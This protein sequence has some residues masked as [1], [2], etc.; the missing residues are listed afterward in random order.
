[1]QTT[2][3]RAHLKLKRARPFVSA[4]TALLADAALLTMAAAAFLSVT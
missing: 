3:T 1:M 2:D 4:K